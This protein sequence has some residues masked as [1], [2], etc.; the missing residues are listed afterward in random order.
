M[1][2][3]GGRTDSVR[4]ASCLATNGRTHEGTG[5]LNFSSLSLSLSQ[6]LSSALP[7][8]FLGS[9]RARA[10]A[11]GRLATD[12]RLWQRLWKRVR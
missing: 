5:K 1:N 6:Y 2:G 4:Q 10:L 12:G 8:S 11:L 7:V 3:R 9:F